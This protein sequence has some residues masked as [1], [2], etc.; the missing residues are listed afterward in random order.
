MAHSQWLQKLTLLLTSSA[1]AL[2]VGE[3][4]LRVA[5]VR[6]HSQQYFT[7]LDFNLG[8]VGRSG[9][10]GWYFD[11]GEAYVR[12]NRDGVRDREHSIAKPPAAVRIAVLGDS[13][14]EAL[15]VP[16]EKTFWSVMERDL[17]SCP[18]LG[19][20][21]TVEAL[22]F[23]VSG[24]G[25]GQELLMLR[26][27]VWKYSPDVVLLA[28]FAGNDLADNYRPLSS[29]SKQ[30]PYFVYEGDRLILD[31]GF[32][33][34]QKHSILS[35]GAMRPVLADLTNRLRL[36][37]LIYEARLRL[38]KR[39]A[40][41]HPEPRGWPFNENEGF[42]GNEAG[43]DNTMFLSPQDA[44][45]KEAWR[46]T[47]GLLLAMRDEVKVH[48][49]EFWIVTVT[50]SVQVHP[51]RAVRLAFMKGLC[52]DTLLYPDLRIAAFGRQ[53]G[54]PVITLAPTFA[55]YAE[56]RKVF[57]HGFKNTRL[58]TGHW[59]E[60]GHHLAGQIIAERL[61]G[62]SAKVNPEHGSLR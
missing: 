20:K 29:H 25:T 33:Q 50:R 35:M 55:E 6:F 46:V 11:E 43:T 27:K 26:Q 10:E 23:G 32:H 39:M 48:G 31:A 54:I 9:A 16:K 8:W 41:A 36:L 4:V 24:Y 19:Q 58:G 13:F 57:L 52:V 1:L 15:Q 14:T 40:P 7:A 49:A 62:G 5:G 37:Q 44:N 22:N 59:N 18:Q 30:A 61:C 21:R 42:S 45:W 60:D 34:F 56:T 47:E 51:D 3:V 28:F 17:S 53:E 38:A 12:I 2:L